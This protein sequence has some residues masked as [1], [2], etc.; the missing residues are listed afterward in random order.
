LEEKKRRKKKKEGKKG[1]GKEG[2]RGGYPPAAAGVVRSGCSCAC[3]LC[4]LRCWLLAISNKV[5][6]PL[7]I[8]II[9]ISA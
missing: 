1:A 8:Y 4:L 2:R 6:L 5:L 7:P 9:S 3:A